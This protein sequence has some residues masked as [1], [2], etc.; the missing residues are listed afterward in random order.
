M[1]P[2]ALVSLLFAS[3]L[4]HAAAYQ[5][6]RPD[7]TLAFQDKPCPGAQGYEI[8]VDGIL[9]TRQREEVANPS[10][11]NVAPAVSPDQIDISG[12]WCAYGMSATPDG[13]VDSSRTGTWVFTATTVMHSTPTTEM[14]TA[15]Y[16]RNGNDLVIS[17]DSA[18]GNT[19]WVVTRGK[20]TELIL[21]SASSGSH[22]LRR[23][24]CLSASR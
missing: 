13:E 8:E 23:G 20:G 14:I 18:L 10:V 17:G 9:T 5:C 22:H 12:R 2:L 21:T 6:K 3:S 11:I 7:G 15:P 4:A 24:S 1:K 16:D 19:A